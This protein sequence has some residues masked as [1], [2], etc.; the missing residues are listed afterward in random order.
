MGQVAT[1]FHARSSWTTTATKSTGVASRRRPWDFQ[2]LKPWGWDWE[3]FQCPFCRD[4]FDTVFPEIW[5]FESNALR[6][7][8]SAQDIDLFY[9][10]FM[11]TAKQGHESARAWFRPGGPAED[12]LFVC[13]SQAI[14]VLVGTLVRLVEEVTQWPS[15]P[16]TQ[17]V[18]GSLVGHFAAPDESMDILIMKRSPFSKVRWAQGIWPVLTCLNC[19]LAWDQSLGRVAVMEQF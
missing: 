16:V 10:H 2:L 7:G 6:P 8:L 5:E 15:D 14:S 11:M 19:E 4:F 17:F 18:G 13:L 12:W 9:I 1:D 3:H